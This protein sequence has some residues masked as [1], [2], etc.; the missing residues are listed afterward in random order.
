MPTKT[1]SH[2]LKKEI[3]E[4]VKAL[5]DDAQPGSKMHEE[6]KGAL[7]VLLVKNLSASIDRH[8]KASSKLSNRILWLNI[9]LGIFTIAGTILAIYSFIN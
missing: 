6:I 5:C 4:L 2:Y 9:V 8:E 7:Y 3:P 1:E